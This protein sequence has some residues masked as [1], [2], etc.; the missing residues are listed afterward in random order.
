LRWDQSAQLCNHPDNAASNLPARVDVYGDQPYPPC[1]GTPCLQQPSDVIKII[2]AARQKEKDGSGNPLPPLSLPGNFNSIRSDQKLVALINLE[3]QD[4]GLAPFPTPTTPVPAYVPANGNI[5]LSWEAHNHAV[6]LAAFYRLADG[7]TN[8]T[9][10]GDPLVHSNGIEGCFITRINA[11]P[12]FSNVQP[13]S[14]AETDGQSPENAVYGWLYQDGQSTWGHRQGLLGVTDSTPDNDHCFTQI[15]A[16]SA[17]SPNRALARGYTANTPD[18]FYIVDLVG[19]EKGRL[20]TVGSTS[21][22]R[23]PLGVSNPQM[24]AVD[25][26]YQWIVF[27]LDNGIR[28]VTSYQNPQ[29]KEISYQ[30]PQWKQIAAGAPG[31]GGTACATLQYPTRC[32][33]LSPGAVVIG[34]DFFD[35]FVCGQPQK[36]SVQQ[37]FQNR[38]L[39]G[40]FCGVVPP[41][42]VT[43]ISPG[44]GVAAGGDT[45]TVTGSEFT[46]ATSVQ[47]GTSSASGMTVVSDTQI[48]ATSPAGSGTVYVT[49]V[50]PDGPSGTSVADQFTYN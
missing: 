26:F 4:R 35:S 50:R 29:W 30:S 14:E 11:I 32:N 1:S 34:F 44:R 12:G 21:G 23:G 41:P 9:C 31:A 7:G 13:A 5:P 18:Y 8:N 28:S 17:L 47:F 15:G 38:W 6:F 2:N 49:V 48:T 33:S 20:A 45:V 22:P 19:E 39:P 3:R 43:A 46:G 27:E 37:G 24:N 16:G 40:D 42:V 10:N 36:G 25:I